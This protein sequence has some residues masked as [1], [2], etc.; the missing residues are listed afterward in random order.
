MS[1]IFLTIQRLMVLSSKSWILSQVLELF[2]DEIRKLC[3]VFHC[4]QHLILGGD[5]NARLCSYGDHLLTNKDK[6]LVNTIRTSCFKA[7]KNGKPAFHC[8]RNSRTVTSALDL[9]FPIQLLC[10]LNEIVSMSLKV[11][12][13]TLPFY[14]KVTVVS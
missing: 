7:L 6:I 4:E 10:Y 5:F 9:S 2:R 3:D 13:N 1:D 8:N 11:K 12:A 14:F